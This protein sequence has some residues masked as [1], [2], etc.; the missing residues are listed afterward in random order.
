MT[1]SGYFD[2]EKVIDKKAQVRRARIIALALSGAA[3]ISM[4]FCVFDYIQKANADEAREQLE[5]LKVELLKQTELADQ[6]AE[7]ARASI[8]EADRQHTMAVEFSSKLEQ[9]KSSK[10]IR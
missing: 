6:N 8:M 9:C 5:Q 10:Q 7:L 3:F 4:I 1:Q 2:G